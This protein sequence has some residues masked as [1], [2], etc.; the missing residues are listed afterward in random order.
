MLFHN[1]NPLLSCVQTHELPFNGHIANGYSWT[2][3]QFYIFIIL[4]MLMY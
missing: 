4:A 2:N 1:T 3:I